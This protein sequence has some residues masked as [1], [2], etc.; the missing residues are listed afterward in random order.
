MIRDI[1]KMGD[2]RLRT[3]ARPVPDPCDPE[4]AAIVT[5]MLDTMHAAQGV[6]LAAPQIGIDLRIMVFGFEANARYPDEPPVP[7]TVLIN[8]DFEVLGDERA[9]GWEGCLSIPGLRGAVSRAV[10]I[11]YHGTMLDGGTLVREA[12]GFH[13]RIVQHE[14]DHLDGILYPD[15][16]SDT[17]RFGFVEAL[18]PDSPLARLGQA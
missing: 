8:P 15:R 16:L 14:H 11:C 9:D 13:A 3:V 17:R 4:V 12:R 2:A 18:F 7:T 1:L 5:D 6:G 10:H